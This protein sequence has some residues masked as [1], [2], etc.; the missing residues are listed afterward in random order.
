MVSLRSENSEFFRPSSKARSASGK[1]MIASM[2]GFAVASREL[3]EATLNVEVRSVNHRFLDIQ[4][5][6]P[7]E[8]RSLESE[9][10]ELL[11]GRLTRGK[12]DC[13]IGL[14]PKPALQHG[15]ALN[16]E[17]LERLKSLEL[18]VRS[19]FPQAPGLTVSDVLRWPGVFDQATLSADTVREPCLALLEQALN[20]LVAARRRE[21]ERLK[22]LLRERVARME[23][24]VEE[25]TPRIPALIAAYQERLSNRLREA[26]LNL[27]DERIRQE[28][29]LFASKIDVDEELSRLTAHLQEVKRVL[30]SGGPAGKRLDFL[31]QELNREANT[32]GAK[33]VD[34]E[35]SRIAMELKVLIEQMREQIQN[36]E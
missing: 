36:I 34:A 6:L 22:E 7:D 20:D 19:A 31:M 17:A 33:S 4:T 5:R 24:L 27:E 26:M 15:A 10:R 14:V 12:V 21:G 13:R 32:L 3:P 23:A 9:V 35:V 8:L 1:S 29:M 16:A 2:T 11:A 30:A 28:F 18:S 25:V